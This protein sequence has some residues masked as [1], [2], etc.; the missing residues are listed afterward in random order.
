MAFFDFSVPGN[1]TNENERGALTNVGTKNMSKLNDQLGPT[2]RFQVNQAIESRAGLRF[3]YA[4]GVAVTA[5]FQSYR[6]PG[7]STA[8]SRA[9][10]RSLQQSKGPAVRWLPFYEN[11][12]IQESRKALYASTPIFLRNEPQRL[13]TG[14][15]ARKFKVDVHYSIYHM[16]MM[17]P[18]ALLLQ[19]FTG[20]E[21][22]FAQGEM[23]AIK[24]YVRSVVQRDTGIVSTQGGNYDAMKEAISQIHDRAADGSEG[25]Y[26]PLPAKVD[27]QF[28]S[29]L[30]YTMF[31]TKGY[32]EIFGLLQYALNHI[33]SSVMGSVQAPIK[34]PPV[35]ELKWGTM[36]NYVPCIV[37]D[38][39]IAP[40]EEAG[41]DPKSLM[42]QRI[43]VSLSMEEF[44]QQHGSLWG[45][46]TI[47]GS[48]PGWDTVMELGGMD[49]Y[50]TEPNQPYATEF[51]NITNS[52]KNRTAHANTPV[53]PYTDPNAPE[54][55][56]FFGGLF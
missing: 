42:A 44:R 15:E 14:S 28:N 22:E 24:K 25:P 36:Y 52:V 21:R 55:E 45:D 29:G 56:G 46:P 49:G 54:D 2:N 38:Y 43:K 7:M 23:L 18:T 3:N 48:L 53:L 50:Q 39:K 47:T 26:G 20:E 9:T 51:Q 33:R 6:P 37:T 1:L 11:P 8:Q 40:V 12:T 5:D 27:S 4:Y 31:V 34:G 10:S 19:I 41:Y 32:Q 35:V 13:Y 30:V 16:A 17:C